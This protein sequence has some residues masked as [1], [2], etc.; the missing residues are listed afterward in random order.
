MFPNIRQRKCFFNPYLS[1]KRVFFVVNIEEFIVLLTNIVKLRIGNQF[2]NPLI[3]N[4][5]HFITVGK[6]GFISFFSMF[7][8]LIG[9]INVVYISPP[10]DNSLP[11]A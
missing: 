9:T 1:S 8:K 10:R 6:F 3:R 4:C 7:Q 5:I 11:N 2:D